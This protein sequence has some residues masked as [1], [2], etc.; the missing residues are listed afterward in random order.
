MT[1]SRQKVPEPRGSRYRDRAGQPS[2]DGLPSARGTDRE[3]DNWSSDSRFS[4]GK[5]RLHPGPVNI[6]SAAVSPAAHSG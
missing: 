2:L 4:L 1:M 3:E 5:H 6:K